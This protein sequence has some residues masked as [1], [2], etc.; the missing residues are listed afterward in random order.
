MEALLD[1]TTDRKELN[2]R[3]KKEFPKEAYLEIRDY[4]LGKSL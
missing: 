2:A 1:E 3:L 4:A